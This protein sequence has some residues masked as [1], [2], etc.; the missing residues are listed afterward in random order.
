M[1]NDLAICAIV[2]EQDARYYIQDWLE[3]HR[4]LR[5]KPFLPIL[6]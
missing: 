1:K 5:C 2:G 3:W 4:A 6:E